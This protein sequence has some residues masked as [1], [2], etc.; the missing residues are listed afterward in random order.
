[1]CHVEVVAITLGLTLEGLED[2]IGA[3]ALL[4]C[5]VL[6]QLGA[7][8][9]HPARSTGDIAASQRFFISLTNTVL[10]CAQARARQTRLRPLMARSGHARP[11]GGRLR[12]P[13]PGSSNGLRHLPIKDL[14]DEPRTLCGRVVA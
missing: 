7:V 11:G 5:G 8:P 4:L 3:A 12:R 13:M 9:S 1:M 6:T 14:S 2:A 10:A